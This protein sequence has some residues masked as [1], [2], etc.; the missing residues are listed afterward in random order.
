VIVLDE[1]TTPSMRE[2]FSALMSTSTNVDMAVAH[3]RLAGID[4]RPGEVGNLRRL[5]LV[6]GKLDADAL[7]QTE[8]RPI[9]Q[10]QRL[11]VLVGS[12][13]LEV[14]TVPRFQWRPDFSV[15]DKAALI[16]AH[17]TELPY[18]ND[19]I[20]LTCVV[21]DHHAIRRCAH[22]FEQMWEQGYDVLPVVVETLDQL[23]HATA[24]T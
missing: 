5:R 1:L 6:M 15:F 2:T 8:S 22:R 17:Y 14:R 20:A 7:L 11:R 4:V 23:L 10:L 19:G 18:P 3:M 12:G 16:G 9:E 13:L 24:A 21:T